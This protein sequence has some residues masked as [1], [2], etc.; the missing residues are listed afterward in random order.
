[1]D[2]FKGIRLNKVFCYVYIIIFFFG[3]IKCVVF[4]SMILSVVWLW[5]VCVIYLR[6]EV[7]FIFF[8]FFE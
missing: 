8:R 7:M 4:I 1:M 6:D 5:I 3:V 2:Y